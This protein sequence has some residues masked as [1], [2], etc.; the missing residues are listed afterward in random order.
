MAQAQL[1]RALTARAV[2][3]AAAVAAGALV[4]LAT[5]LGAQ[6]TDG[7][8]LNRLRARAAA[9]A[10]EA[11]VFTRTVARRGEAL[12]SEARAT[13]AAARERLRRSA[14]DQPIAA[15]GLAQ[16]FDFDAMVKAAGDAGQTDS[17]PRLIAFASLSMPTTALRQM[18]ADVGRAGGA[19]VFRG[20]PGQSAKTFTTAL[21]QVLPAGPVQPGLGIDPR[22]FRAFGIAE[23]PAYVVTSGPVDLCDV[24]D[25]RSDPPP[26]DIVRGNVTVGYALDLFAHGGGPGASAA[27]A[28]ARQLEQR[29]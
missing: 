14:A 29:R 4:G 23:V 24:F 10:G 17:A 26:H 27:T 20:F 6:G 12:A 1:L 16:A 15:S 28:F 2:L 22:L 21:A 5:P 8:D 9:R 3:P 25:C 19:V 7:I 11:E 18:I 13:A